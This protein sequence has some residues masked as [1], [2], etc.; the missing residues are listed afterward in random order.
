MEKKVEKVIGQRVE[1]PE[2]IFK[3]IT[4]NSEWMII[5]YYIGGKN[6]FVVVKLLDKKKA[7][8]GMGAP[9]SQLYVPKTVQNTCK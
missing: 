8:R 1:S 6:C 5:T 2:M 4:K 9:V 3:C 7:P